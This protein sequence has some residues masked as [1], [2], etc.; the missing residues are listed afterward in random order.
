MCAILLKTM[1]NINKVLLQFFDVINLV[2]AAA[3]LPICVII[4][5]GD[6]WRQCLSVGIR[7]KV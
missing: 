5:A 7:V 1:P 4:N 6:K 3:F 2:D